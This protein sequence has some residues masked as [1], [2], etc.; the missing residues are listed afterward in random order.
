MLAKVFDVEFNHFAG[1]AFLRFYKV[2]SS[3]FYAV[4]TESRTFYFQW[5]VLCHSTQRERCPYT[6]YE[7]LKFLRPTKHYSSA[8][9]CRW[10][11]TNNRWRYYAPSVGWIEQS[12]PRI[13]TVTYVISL[14]TSCARR[15][16][17]FSLQFDAQL[18]SKLY[19]FQASRVSDNSPLSLKLQGR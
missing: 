9:P 5:L 17:S 11:D 18:A 15:S 12:K 2:N 8:W 10:T 7:I 6:V 16:E 1:I 13:E 3:T 14:L 4:P 19:A